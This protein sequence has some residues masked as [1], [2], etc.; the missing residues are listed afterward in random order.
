MT[1]K[2]QMDPRSRRHEALRN[3]ASAH[4]A[5]DRAAQRLAGVRRPLA[6]AA[7]ALGLGP[8]EGSGPR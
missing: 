1:P 2:H 4:E 6:P 3:L 5:L 7:L 8:P